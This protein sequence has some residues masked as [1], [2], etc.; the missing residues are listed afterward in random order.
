MIFEH[1]RQ[2]KFIEDCEFNELYPIRV[3]KLSLRHWTPVEVAKKAANFLVNQPNKKILDI[4]SGAGKFCLIGAA[5]T[6]GIF[7]GVEQ[8][9][10]L[11]K[12]S[13]RIAKKHK[14][15][16]VEFIHSNITEISFSDYDAFYFYNS[17]QENIDRS[18]PI[19]KLIAPSEEL[20]KIYTRYLR[21][22]LDKTAKGTRLVT[23]WSNWKEIPESFNLEF[24]DHRGALSFW[25]KIV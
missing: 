16:N 7:Y 4:G 19:D 15:D 21:D 20:Y 1:L 6:N 13:K 2:N 12:L 22:Q 5:S 11:V 18:C 9:E 10:S 24:L 23:Y 25:K 8:R 3:K 17:F 14:I